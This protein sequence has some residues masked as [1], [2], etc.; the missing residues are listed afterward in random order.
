MKLRPC[1]EEDLKLFYPPE[2]RSISTV[3]TYK[4][5]GGL[6]CIDWDT[7][8]IKLYGDFYGNDDRWSLLDIN[9][10]PCSMNEISIGAEE[11]NIR[12]DCIYD[13]QT[14]LDYIGTFSNSFTT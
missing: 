7:T 2:S 14:A 1:S 11:A 6:Q 8:D 10:V 9:A 4:N 13:K 12:D 5:T 3:E